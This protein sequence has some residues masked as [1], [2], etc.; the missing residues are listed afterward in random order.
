MSADVD[1]HYLVVHFNE[2]EQPPRRLLQERLKNQCLLGPFPV[3]WCDAS[4][5]TIWAIC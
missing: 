3:H 2:N 1:T 5:L 4:V